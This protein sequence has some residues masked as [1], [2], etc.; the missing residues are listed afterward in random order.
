MLFEILKYEIEIEVKTGLHI[1]SGNSSLRIGSVDEEF[2]RHPNTKE[3]Y[4]PGSSLKGKIRSLLEYFYGIIPLRAKTAN[5]QESNGG[6]LSIQDLLNLKKIIQDN[7]SNKEIYDE[8]KVTSI[9]KLFGV[10]VQD[11]N[12]KDIPDDLKIGLTRL[13]ISDFTLI[14]NDENPNVFEIKTE[15]TVNRDYGSSTKNFTSLTER[16]TSGT[17]FIGFINIKIFNDEVYKDSKEEFKEM[18]F[19]GLYLL[20]NDA[21]GAASSRGYGRVKISFKNDKVNKEYIDFSNRM[22]EKITSF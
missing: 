16:V 19:T 7:E 13:S 2:V 20:D 5:F 18:L 8:N 22:D 1:G 3:P 12:I 21:L 11:Y 15:T 4:I 10:P 6:V 17:K 9:L 14:H